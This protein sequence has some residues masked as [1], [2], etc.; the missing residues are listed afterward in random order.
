MIVFVGSQKGRRSK[1]ELA[2]NI[3]TALAVN[4]KDV[5]FA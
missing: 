3:A 2:T 1:S 5:I 4:G